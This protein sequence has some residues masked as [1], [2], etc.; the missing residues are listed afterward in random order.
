MKW[1]REIEGEL[2]WG[3]I[4]VRSQLCTKNTTLLWFQYK[5]LHRILT[6]NTYVSKFTDSSPLCTF[7]GSN[8]ETLLHLF[9]ECEH[10]REV[11]FNMQEMIRNRLGCYISFTKRNIVMGLEDD[12][13]PDQGSRVAIQRGIL[14]GKYYIYRCK[15]GHGRINIADLKRF[16]DF[17]T[18]AEFSC[19]NKGRTEDNGN[20]YEKHEMLCLLSQKPLE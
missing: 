18:R 4:Y 11:W 16:F 2:K 7:C 14:L 6:T 15:A 10:I 3:D 1:G 8:R 5:L 19:V 17:Y 20:R 9:V 13:I 12:E